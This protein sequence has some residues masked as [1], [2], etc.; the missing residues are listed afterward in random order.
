MKRYATLAAGVIV[1]GPCADVVIGVDRM[2][3]STM[4]FPEEPEHMIMYGY[5]P[6]G[7]L[8]VTCEPVAEPLLLAVHVVA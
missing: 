7:R 2:H 5:V 4:L 8:M 3:Q 6:A 1:T